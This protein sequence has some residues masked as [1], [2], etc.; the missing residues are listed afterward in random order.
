MGLV[1]RR[2]GGGVKTT[3]LDTG[4]QGDA[5]RG[6]KNT[7]L[8]G[9]PG[10]TFRDGT[11]TADR[12]FD[13]TVIGATITDNDDGTGILTIADVAD[14]G[15]LDSA[16]GG[17][18]VVYTSIAAGAA[19]TLDL[20]EENVFDITLSANLTLTFTNIPSG[21]VL[22]IWTFIIRQPASGGP[23]TVTWPAAVQWQASTGATGG[24][25]PTLFT[26]AS[27]VDVFEVT[28]LDAGTTYGAASRRGD[29]RLLLNLTS[30]DPHTQYVLE[31]LVDAKGDLL[32][33]T[34]ADT[35]ARVA[36]GAN[37]YLLT[38]DSTA[39]TG[40]AWA[41]AENAGHYEVL[42]TGASPADPLETGSGTDWLYVWVP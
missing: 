41:A 19:L 25:A 9:T 34:A 20:A 24:T 31:T 14:G 22:R 12:I 36:V 1:L 35:A 7:N 3:N 32:A 2:V 33:G 37:G 38:A 27:A 26:T 23:Y 8:S 13:L 18:A 15:F 16:G 28:T 5:T 30:G 11:T 42:M 39:S 4:H 17:G 6:R 40:V 21:D 10:Q 29:H